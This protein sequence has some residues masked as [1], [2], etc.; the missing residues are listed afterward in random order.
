VELLSPLQIY[1]YIFLLLSIFV[2][3]DWQ[4]SSDP[5]GLPTAAAGRRAASM[6][7]M[8]IKRERRER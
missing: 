1:L 6:F 5:L 8:F 3:V 2:V 4:E 7:L